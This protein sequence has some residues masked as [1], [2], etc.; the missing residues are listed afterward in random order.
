MRGQLFDLVRQERYAHEAAVS[1]DTVVNTGE[2][3]ED[4]WALADSIPAAEPS[5]PH[6]D[7]FDLRAA[8]ARVDARGRLV[9]R[10]IYEDGFTLTEIGQQIGLSKERTFQLKKAA[11]EALRAAA[12]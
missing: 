2:K 5:L 11:L 3:Y 10:L 6:E 4:A 12:S 7:A 8:L 1:L 9:L